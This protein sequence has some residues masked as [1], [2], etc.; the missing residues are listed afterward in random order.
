VDGTCSGLYSVAG[1]G[2]SS[3]E[4]SGSAATTFM[5]FDFLL[6]LKYRVYWTHTNQ[7]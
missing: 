4:F 6:H 3:T 7:N 2:I 5:M 1:F